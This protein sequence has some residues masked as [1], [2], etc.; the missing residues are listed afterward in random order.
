ML[1][2]NFLEMLSVE[3]GASRNTLLAYAHDLQDFEQF[4]PAGVSLKTAQAEHIEA[5]LQDL[6]AR[7]FQTRSAARRLSAIKQFYR[8]LYGEKI[9]TD[10]PASLFQTPKSAPSLPRTLGE[11]H[12]ASLLDHCA[13]KAQQDGLSSSKKLAALRQYAM[14]ELLYASGMRVS[15]LV[16]MKHQIMKAEEPFISVTGK[17]NR[18]RLV[19]VSRMAMAA[20]GAYRR[21]LESQKAASSPYA[22]PARSRQDHMTRQAFARDLKAVA[23]SAGLDPQK[24]SPHVL[25]HAFASHMLA[26]GADLRSLQVFLGHKDIATTQIYTHVLEERLV[27]LVETYHPLGRKQD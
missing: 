2:D 1:L 23:L 26:H 7:G 11:D 13:Q 3:R 15:E 20:Y 5:Y 12:V 14:M 27:D 18:Q 8:F 17:G 24:L 9:R 25:R 16:S 4:L 6:H 10:D 22:F 19:P 21:E